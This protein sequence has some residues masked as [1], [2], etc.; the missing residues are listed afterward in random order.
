M[1]NVQEDHSDRCET[2]R[3]TPCTSGLPDREQDDGVELEHVGVHRTQRSPTPQ[4]RPN[5]SPAQPRSPSVALRG[6]KRNTT[7]SPVPEEATHTSTNDAQ[8]EA[9]RKKPRALAAVHS[10]VDT[11]KRGQGLFGLL[12]ST[13]SQFKRDAES[14]R[15]SSAAQRRAQIEARLADKLKLSERAMDATQQRRALVWQARQLAEQIG[16]GDAQRKTIR[17]MKRR[18]ASFLHTPHHATSTR[19]HHRLAAHI[20][21][22]HTATR[23]MRDAD[24]GFSVYFLPGKTLPEQEDML[25]DQEDSVDENID[26]FDDHWDETRTKLLRQLDEV[27]AKLSQT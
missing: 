24:R 18:M 16:S 12:T 3:S 19:G 15:A 6:V 14:D 5:S 7:C 10:D 27:K 25:N 23:R 4:S 8:C 20:P 26:A 13:L 1:A 9:V 2:V 21:M 17:A 11:K 22:S